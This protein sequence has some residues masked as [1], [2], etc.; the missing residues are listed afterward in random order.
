MIKKGGEHVITLRLMLIS[1]E[2]IKFKNDDEETIRYKYI[3]LS[4]TGKAYTAFHDEK[5]YPERV[6]DSSTYDDARAHV[7]KVTPREWE[8]KLSYKVD[9]AHHVD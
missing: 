5:V 7:Y 1:L 6:V 4:E 3:F 9:L 8:G 2:P